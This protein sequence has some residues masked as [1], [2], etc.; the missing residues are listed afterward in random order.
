MRFIDWLIKIPED[1]MLTC[2]EQIKKIAEEEAEE[3]D[4]PYV[5]MFD[6]LARLEGKQEGKQEGRQEGLQEGR[7][8]EIRMLL[9]KQIRRRFPTTVTAKHL[10]LINEADTDTLALWAEKLID[11]KTIDEVFA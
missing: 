1:L 5:S 8:E 4:V 6:Q 7:Q 2:N 3:W 9:D 11:A 10:H